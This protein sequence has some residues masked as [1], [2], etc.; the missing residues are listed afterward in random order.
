MSFCTLSLAFLCLFHGLFLPISPLNKIFRFSDHMTACCQCDIR[1]CR[2]IPVLREI[3][4]RK[5]LLANVYNGHNGYVLI[6][7]YMDRFF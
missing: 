6:L 4:E 5:I 1:D 3:E 2:K 7:V